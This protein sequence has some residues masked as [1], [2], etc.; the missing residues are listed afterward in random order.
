MNKSIFYLLLSFALSFAI[1]GCGDTEAN[2]NK[3]NQAEIT[4][5]EDLG[6]ESVDGGL[7][8]LDFLQG[9]WVSTDDSKSEMKIEGMSRIQYYDGEALETENFIL[10]NECTEDTNTTNPKDGEYLVA[11]SAG[12]VYCYYIEKL[13]DNN[14]E[15]QYQDRG[16]TLTYTKK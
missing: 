6:T 15:L 14:L 12:D 7:T 3:T 9:T 1:V 11:F 13:D 16:T 2:E 5:I 10:A 8:K 4:E